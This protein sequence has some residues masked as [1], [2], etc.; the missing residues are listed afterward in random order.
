MYK[1]LIMTLFWQAELC[2]LSQWLAIRSSRFTLVKINNL[3]CPIQKILLK[4]SKTHYKMK[5]NAAKGYDKYKLNSKFMLI[6]KMLI[7]WFKMQP[8]QIN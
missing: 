2:A 8:T 7:F 4:S 3:I 6:I 5:K 1:N